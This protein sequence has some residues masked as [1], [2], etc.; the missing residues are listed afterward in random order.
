MQSLHI[1]WHSQLPAWV[2]AIGD[3]E[4]LT[5]V[6]KDHVTAVMEHYKGKIYAWVRA[7]HFQYVCKAT[8]DISTRMS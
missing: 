8:A 5:Q 7:T 3:K 2:E 6:I 1:V 4:T